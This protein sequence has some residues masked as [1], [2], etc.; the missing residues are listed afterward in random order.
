VRLKAARGQIAPQGSPQI[1]PPS[2]PS[3]STIAGLGLDQSERRRGTLKSHGAR[4][5]GVF[6]QLEA[7]FV[8][9][10]PDANGAGVH[11]ECRASGML[12]ELAD[13]DWE[14]PPLE[15]P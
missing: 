2:G 4:D 6:M 5:R 10:V 1:L 12:Y 15:G 14:E 11:A 8:V 7:L 13:E 9:D 3:K